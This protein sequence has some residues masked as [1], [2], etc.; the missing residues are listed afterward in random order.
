[1]VQCHWACM[2][3][4]VIARILKLGAQNWQL[5]FIEHPSFHGRSKY[6]Q[7]TTINMYLFNEI[8]HVQWHGSFIEVKKRFMNLCL[9]LIF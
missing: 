8:K 2:H 9:K 3:L 7:I 1:M 4:R 5:T 6:T